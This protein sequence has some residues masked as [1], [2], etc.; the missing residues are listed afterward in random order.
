MGERKV[1]PAVRRRGATAG[2][3]WLAAFLLCAGFAAAIAPGSAAGDELARLVA[4]VNE[5][6][7]ANGLDPVALDE[8]LSEAAQ[9]QAEARA[10]AGGLGHDGPNGGLTA[11][12]Q[13]AGYA[14]ATA[15]ENLGGGAPAPEETVAGWTQSPPHAR[16][17]LIAGIRDAG[18]GHAAGKPGD[19]F[20]DYWCL[21]LAEPALP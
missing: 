16:N 17:L 18:A 6:R 12:L 21:I 20:T 15:A 9:G 14:F 4:A 8:R 11:R 13:R 5:F 19:L 7:A 2:L 1:T 10:A 3:A